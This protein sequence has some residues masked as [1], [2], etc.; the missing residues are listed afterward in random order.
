M[1]PAGEYAIDEGRPNLLLAG[2]GVRLLG[3]GRPTGVWPRLC[4]ARLA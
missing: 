3:E 4:A 1:L 2:K